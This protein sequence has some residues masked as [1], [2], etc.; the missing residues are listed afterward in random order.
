MRLTKILNDELLT[1]IKRYSGYQQFPLT[2][3]Q[4]TSFGRYSIL[5]NIFKIMSSAV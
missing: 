4:F 5:L 2:I 1:A 3:E